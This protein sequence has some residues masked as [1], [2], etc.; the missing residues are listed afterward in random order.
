MTDLSQDGRDQVRAGAARQTARIFAE[1]MDRRGATA[2]VVALVA[3]GMIAGIVNQVWR[4]RTKAFG[5]WQV[6]RVLHSMLRA[7]IREICR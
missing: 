4:N 2:E 7:A 1:I 3:E 6:R 5:R